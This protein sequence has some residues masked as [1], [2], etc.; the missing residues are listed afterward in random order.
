MLASRVSKAFGPTA[1]PFRQHVSIAA[2]ELPEVDVSPVLAELTNRFKIASKNINLN[3]NTGQALAT[4]FYGKTLDEMVKVSNQAQQQNQQIK[5]KNRFGLVSA[6][7]KEQSMNQAF[8]AKAYEE[9]LASHAAADTMQMQASND[10]LEAIYADKQDNMYL[11]SMIMMHPE[12][13]EEADW[14]SKLLQ[15]RTFSRNPDFNKIYTK[16]LAT[17]VD[18]KPVTK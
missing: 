9:M 12:L 10:V 13:E 8:D 11:D 14:K 16:P 3:S 1:L 5:A 15:R 7:N 4:N 6:T 18:N 17:K 2:E